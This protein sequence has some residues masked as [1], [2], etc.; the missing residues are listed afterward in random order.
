VQHNL[1]ETAN[2][3]LEQKVGF[4]S[5]SIR[6]FVNL[7]TCDHHLDIQQTTLT[8]NLSWGDSP[9]LKIDTNEYMLYAGMMYVVSYVFLKERKYYQFSEKPSPRLWNESVF[10]KK[11]KQIY[12]NK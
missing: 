8:N 10:S 2:C 12:S 7:K 3:N 5:S 1:R 9:K 4:L 6:V 11:K